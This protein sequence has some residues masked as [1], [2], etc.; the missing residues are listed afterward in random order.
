MVGQAEHDR[1][2]DVVRHGLHIV[3]RDALTLG[4]GRDLLYLRDKAAHKIAAD[5]DEALHRLCVRAL[6]RGGKAPR[7]PVHKLPL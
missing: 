6:P 2:R 7:Y 4:V 1:L 5:E 3:D